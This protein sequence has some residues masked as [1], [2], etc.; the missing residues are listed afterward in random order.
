MGKTSVLAIT[1]NGVSIG[2]NLKKLFPEWSVFAPSKLSN[3]KTE[4]IWYSEPTSEKIVELFKNNNALIC[5]FSL[6]AVI[7]LIAPYLKDKKTDPAVIVIDDKTN[8][9]ISVLSGHIR[10]ANELTKEIADKLGAL[11]VITTAADV[12]KTIAVDL[13]GR[14]FNWKIDDDSTVTKISAHMVNE[15]PIGIF[16]EAGNKNWYKKL[17]KNVLIYENM[18][19]LKKSNSKACLIISDKV[20]D[21]EISKESVIYRPPSLVIGI[22][23]HWDTT[24]E[25]IREGI[26][27]CLDKFQL[28]SKSIAKLVSI[29]KP[30]DVQ[31]LIDLGKEIG[32]P[33]E[34]VNR[35]DLAEISAPNPSET[36]KAFEGTA[37]VSEAAAI[38]VSGGELIVEKQK[39]PPNLTIAI[40]RILN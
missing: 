11:S 10:G 8:F 33:V 28:S 22:G 27:D 26:D 32:I 7:R 30:E 6:G 9:V 4:I 2:E 3:E 13:V 23:L 34:Y 16:Q 1:K 17:P 24:K 38:K 36:V 37:S 25:T 39:F 14:E 31:G 18:E 40:A 19:D 35:E 5:I 21:K 12:N 15:K 29:K 20:I